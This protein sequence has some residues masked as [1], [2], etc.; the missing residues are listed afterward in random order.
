MIVLHF[1]A[2][3][4]GVDRFLGMEE[5]S[6]S[7]PDVSTILFC[8][9]FQSFDLS[10]NRLALEGKLYPYYY[11]FEY[12][13]TSSHLDETELLNFRENMFRDL[14]VE[15]G[16]LKTC[17]NQAVLFGITGAGIVLGLVKESPIAGME[18]FLFLLPIMI[19]LPFWLIFFDK[20]RTISRIVGF[21]RVQERLGMAKSDSG[22]T[23]WESAMN[24]YWEQK[25][26]W[27]TT[28]HKKVI[29]RI[30]KEMGKNRKK[31]YTSIY[32]FTV[33]VIFTALSLVCILIS[34]F[35]MYISS[36]PI[37]LNVILLIIIL[38]LIALLW[39]GYVYIRVRKNDF[40]CVAFWLFIMVAG[41]LIVYSVIF[42][43]AWWMNTINFIHLIYVIAFWI[44]TMLALFTILLNLWIFENLVRGR[45]SY[46]AFEYRWEVILKTPLELSNFNKYKNVQE[47]VE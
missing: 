29:A 21:L 41:S 36:D 9:K 8:E 20:G 26:L 5:A 46:R 34:I 39:F 31:L 33:Y 24:E 38:F 10:R 43:G 44:F 45:Y 3:R 19:L 47:T 17:Q 28:E 12:N 32:W 4:S 13:M 11:H 42:T 23:G 25:D 35:S 37:R 14:R 18:P 16:Q 15:L 30:N 7:I 1:R 27:D 40:N 2:R 6:G 22:A